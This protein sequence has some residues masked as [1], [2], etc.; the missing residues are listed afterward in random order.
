MWSIFCND[1][2]RNHP[3]EMTPLALAPMCALLMAWPWPVPTDGLPLSVEERSCSGHRRKTDFDNNP[4]GFIS[5]SKYADQ[6]PKAFA[7]AIDPHSSSNC[8][9][10]RLAIPAKCGRF[11]G[12]HIRHEVSAAAIAL[13]RRRAGQCGDL[14]RCFGELPIL[15]EGLR[16]T[17]LMADGELIY[18]TP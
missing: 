18:P 4:N 7:R 5:P 12:S 14:H 8:H 15:H 1:P 10:I 13:I 3:I 17:T 11:R 9:S 6:S 16:S 2:M